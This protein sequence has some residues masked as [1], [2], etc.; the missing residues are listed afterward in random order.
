MTADNIKII[1]ISKNYKNFYLAK[2]GKLKDKNLELYDVDIFNIDNEKYKKIK[3]L[4]LNIN[5]DNNDIVNSISNYKFVPFYNYS[6]HIESLKKFNLYSS[7]VSFYYLSE[8]FKPFFLIIL[9]FIVMGYASKFKRNENF[10]KILFFSILIGFVF[11]VFNEIVTALTIINYIPFW[12]AYIIMLGIPLILGL[13][14]SI[15]IEIN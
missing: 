15:N 11:F 2:I 6:K 9:G 4:N 12:F 1:E 10:F 5:F 3:F 7:E 14:Q 8:I 13:Y